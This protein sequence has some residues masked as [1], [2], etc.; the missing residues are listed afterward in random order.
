[1]ANEAV[2][3]ALRAGFRHVD[4]AQAYRNEET[5]GSAIHEWFG[6]D[7][8]AT[9]QASRAVEN[10][11]SPSD[12]SET[13]SSRRKDIWVTTKYIGDDV[14]PLESLKESLKKLQLNYVDLY[15]VHRPEVLVGKR[16]EWWRE[17]EKAR[18]LG[19]AKSIGV[20]NFQQDDLQ[21]LL[22]IAKVKPAVNQVSRQEVQ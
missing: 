7:D 9:Y 19:L 20:S 1:D 16:E 10:D 6:D 14:G 21:E 22:K 3:A 18:E 12:A 15:L 17:F 11:L 2:L 13:S 4:T 8:S 5:V